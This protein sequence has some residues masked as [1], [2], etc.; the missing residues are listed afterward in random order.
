MLHSTGNSIRLACFGEPKKHGLAFAKPCRGAD[1][2]ALS[3]GDVNVARGREGFCVA[4]LFV[5]N[6]DDLAIA[7]GR[8]AWAIAHTVGSCLDVR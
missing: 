6:D 7:C 5:P 8:R 4:P 1:A 3:V 2:R